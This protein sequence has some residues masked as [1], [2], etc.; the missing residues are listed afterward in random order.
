MY[1]NFTE[2]KVSK[3]VIK[4]MVMLSGVAKPR[5]ART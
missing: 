2:S 4:L 3:L 1:C 5:P